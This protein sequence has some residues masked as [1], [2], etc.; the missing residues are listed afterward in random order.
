MADSGFAFA[1]GWPP[2]WAIT[3]LASA[4]PVTKA[5]AIGAFTWRIR[6][7]PFTKRR[8]R[9]SGPDSTSCDSAQRR[10]CDGGSGLGLGPSFD[11]TYVLDLNRHPAGVF[12]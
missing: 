1:A 7:L 3:V 6:T 11:R 5:T 4:T 2:P 9:V 10:Y 8:R 12:T